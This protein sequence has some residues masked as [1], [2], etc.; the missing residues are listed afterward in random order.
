MGKALARGSKRA[1]AKDCLQDKITSKHLW[2][3]IGL[4]LRRE[5]R[6]MVSDTTH[7]ILRSQSAEPMKSFSWDAV[8]NEL[9]QH[10]PTLLFILRACTQT[11]VERSNV[12]AVIGTCAV[13][14]LKHRYDRMSMFQKIVSIIL[15]AGHCSKQVRNI[16]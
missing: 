4:R 14:L 16:I 2:D 1:L 12:K 3:L 13:I 15:Y 10:A 5:L 9:L 6:N 7:S 11:R 8:I